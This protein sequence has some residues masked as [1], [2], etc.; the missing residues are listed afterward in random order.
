MLKFFVNNQDKKTNG[1]TKTYM[2]PE[3]PITGAD[4]RFTSII[5]WPPHWVDI[6]SESGWE[7][8]QKSHHWLPF[9][10][11]CQLGNDLSSWKTSVHGMSSQ[12]SEM[13]IFNHLLFNTILSNKT[14]YI[15]SEMFYHFY[16][17]EILFGHNIDLIYWY[18]FKI[19]KATKIETGRSSGIAKYTHAKRTVCVQTKEL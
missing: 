19:N 13:S 16:S 4:K 6:V 5:P 11:H 1:Q 8:C 17:A 7:C 12:C 14:W 3:S 10:I 18:I 15:S 9:D 2:T